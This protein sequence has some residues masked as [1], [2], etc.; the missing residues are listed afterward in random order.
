MDDVET[1]KAQVIAEPAA[2]LLGGLLLA[3]VNPFPDDGRAWDRIEL[4]IICVGGMALWAWWYSSRTITRK[5]CAE[6]EKT[7]RGERAAMAFSF[8]FLGV[9]FFWNAWQPQR[10]QSEE[11]ARPGVE[12][13]V[14]EA[15]EDTTIS[16][17]VGSVLLGL[18]WI[19]LG[20][21][22]FMGS[23]ARPDRWHI[24]VD[25]RLARWHIVVIGTSFI[26]GLL[27]VWWL[28]V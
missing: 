20:G 12:E 18:Y 27:A 5:E 10:Q 14:V 9:L 13:I 23:D 28:A 16:T 21:W 2:V 26:L 22:F 15:G 6:Q 8:F 7:F 17:R 24:A 1:A 19:A 25:A 3:I 11:A 4:V